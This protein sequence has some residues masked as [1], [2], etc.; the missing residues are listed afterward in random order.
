MGGNKFGATP[1]GS[2]AVPS[3]AGADGCAEMA[4]MTSRGSSS[5][6]GK[7]RSH[8]RSFSWCCRLWLWSSDLALGPPAVCCPASWR[9]CCRR[10]R[11]RTW[12]PRASI[13]RA[14]QKSRAHAHTQAHTGTGAQTHR[15]TDAQT[16]AH[17][18]AHGVESPRQCRR[19][20]REKLARV[21]MR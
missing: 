17:A 10:D 13:V 19:A 3:G 4:S 18:Q 16:N 12:G 9:E 2:V 15:R 5:V 11:L 14:S 8:R 1:E 6:G 7:A 21:V 20:M